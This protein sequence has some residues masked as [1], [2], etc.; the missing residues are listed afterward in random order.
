MAV[1]A[2]EVAPIRYVPDDR[3]R[4]AAWLGIPYAEVGDPL[5]HAEHA[6]TGEPVFHQLLHC[7]IV[8]AQT[9]EQQLGQGCKS[10]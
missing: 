3:D 2:V 1:Q 10:R 5:H 7:A 6:L 9:E 4:S 8:H